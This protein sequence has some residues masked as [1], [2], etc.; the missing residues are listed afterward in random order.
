MSRVVK[1]GIFKRFV[2]R[3]PDQARELEDA[4]E[5]MIWA[6]EASQLCLSS[7]RFC[8]VYDEHDQIQEG[9]GGNS[10]AK[11]SRISYFSDFIFQQ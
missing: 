10:Q 6:F 2:E 5:D 1:W 3:Y 11:L 7:Q 9:A 4:Y 8:V